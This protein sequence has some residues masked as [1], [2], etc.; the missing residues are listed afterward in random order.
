MQRSE[1]QTQLAQDP[2]NPVFAEY[3]DQLRRE[4]QYSE[5]LEICYRGLSANPSV[6]RGRLVL[7]RVYY[8]KLFWPFAIRE[9]Q[10]LQKDL[11]HSE[12]LRRLLTALAPE[13]STSVLTERSRNAEDLVSRTTINRERN[14]YHDS[15]E[16]AAV[17]DRDEHTVAEAEFEI[18]DFDLLGE[19]D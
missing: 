12:T 18:D 9:V 7:A 5:A 8:E 3:A 1:V 4:G 14:D 13:E 15:F 6:H 11:P 19:D 16:E 17:I 10:Q 2:G